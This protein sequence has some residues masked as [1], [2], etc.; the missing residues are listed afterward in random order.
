VQPHVVVNE[1]LLND[2]HP[3]D[4]SYL[5][6]ESRLKVESSNRFPPML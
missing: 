4:V 3:H 5:V 6:R 2:G 1:R